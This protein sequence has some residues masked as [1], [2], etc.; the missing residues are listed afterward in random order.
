MTQILTDFPN[1]K[2]GIFRLSICVPLRN[3]RI[4][5]FEFANRPTRH[6]NGASPELA[7][8]LA[9]ASGYRRMESAETFARSLPAVG[10]TSK[11]AGL[12]SHVSQIF[13]VP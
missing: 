4:N 11:L 9:K 5:L 13:T 3:L 6:E 8:D 10:M 7:R 12:L 2:K 1:D